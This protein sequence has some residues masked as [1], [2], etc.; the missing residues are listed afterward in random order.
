MPEAPRPPR[1]PDVDAR[2]SALEASFAVLAAAGRKLD[3]IHAAIVGTPTEA[4]LGERVRALEA[5]VRV[6]KGAALACATA[7]AV[8]WSLFASGPKP[9]HP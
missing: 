4:G 3:E 9:P 6:V 8:A 7:V 2:L 5:F 1:D